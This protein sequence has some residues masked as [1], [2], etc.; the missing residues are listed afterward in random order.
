ML[1]VVQS[2]VR[3]LLCRASGGER[4]RANMRPFD[5]RQITA[6]EPYTMG[7]GVIHNEPSRM[8]LELDMW[9]WHIYCRDHQKLIVKGIFKIQVLPVISDLE[10]APPEFLSNGT[11]FKFSY[12][13]FYFL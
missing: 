12:K 5:A 10:E 8:W 6:L 11:G 1:D 2:R 3:R 9:L 13:I 7:D 4:A